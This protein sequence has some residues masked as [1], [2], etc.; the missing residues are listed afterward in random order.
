VNNLWWHSNA[1]GFRSD[2]RWQNEWDSPTRESGAPNEVGQWHSQGGG[3]S[4][5][6]IQGN[7]FLS[8]FNFPDKFVTQVCSFRQ[9]FLAQ[10]SFLSMLPDV[11][12]NG[13]TVRKRHNI[14]ENKKRTPAKPDICAIFFLL[15][16]ASRNTT[17][18]GRW[19]RNA[20]MDF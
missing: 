16:F 1:E 9:L 17:T 12:A 6:G 18:F 14:H 3:D 8:A 11:L 20:R 15:S 7:V 4:E 19:P 2:S 13:S 10:T 5:E